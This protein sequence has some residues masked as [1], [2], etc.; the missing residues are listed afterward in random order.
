MEF[1]FQE[2]QGY[3]ENHSE[4]ES[5]LLRQVN[6]ETHLHVLNPRM[7][8]GHL[9]GR[10][11]SMISYMI[12]PKN[13]LEIGTY[14]GYASLCMAEGMPP[15]GKLITIDTNEELS[16][17]TRQYFASSPYKN[18]IEMKVGNAKEI[19]LQLTERWDL[20]FIDADKVS[21][22]HYFDL[23]INQV[24]TGGFIIVDNVLWSGKVIDKTIKDTDTEAIRNFNQKVH[25]DT[26]IQNVLIPIRDGLMILRKL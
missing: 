1:P 12:K 6:R 26:R 3:V 15:E 23:V 16:V 5:D 14:T 18:Q 22:C 13:I 17:R 2:I 10:V 25:T 8:S 24:N 11:L 9:Q 21:Y 20:V 7:I 4:P 19:I